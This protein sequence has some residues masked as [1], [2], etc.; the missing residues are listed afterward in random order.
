MESFLVIII[1]IITINFKKFRR[2]LLEDHLISIA[3]ITIIIL[4]IWLTCLIFIR[5]YKPKGAYQFAIL[6]YL[7]MIALLIAF[8]V[9][10]LINYYI[11]FEV[12]LLPIFVLILGW[13]YQP[14]RLIASLFILFYT[15]VASLPL[16]TRLLYINWL[17]GRTALK[18]LLL[19][20]NSIDLILSLFFTLAFLIKLPIFG[21]HLWLPKAHVEAPVAGSII[22]AGVLLK[23]G[24]YGL[25]LRSLILIHLNLINV[26]GVW[27]ML[28]GSLLSILIVTIS[29]IKVI[30]AYSSVV[31]IRMVSLISLSGVRLGALGGII[32][33]ISHGFTSSGIFRAANI[34]YERSHRRSLVSNKGL[35][36]LNPRL[37]AL[38]FLLITLNFAGPF[39]INLASE[40]IIIGG[41]ITLS[42]NYWFPI[43]LICFFSLTYNL[44][45]YAS[46]Q[47]GV[48]Q[49]YLTEYVE[50]NNREIIRTWSHL[51]P[52]VG[53]LFIMRI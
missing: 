35:I 40:I 25:I 20:A 33:I 48:M 9:R 22:L 14:E 26:I 49:A 16:L 17:R 10:S 4:R 1:F 32:M 3:G 30:I 37:T 52:G 8:R 44:I 6:L 45:L 34:I 38:W 13:G 28:G 18:L 50:F 51:W 24:G 21:V 2:I 53:I 29:D 12:V 19:R 31:H 41:L 46:L 15:I 11:F 5:N 23:L 27:A 39:T 36:S 47:Q 43:F 7:I 42:W